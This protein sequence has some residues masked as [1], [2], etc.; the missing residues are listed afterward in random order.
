MGE[1]CVEFETRGAQRRAASPSPDTIDCD[2]T[3]SRPARYAYLN[4]GVVVGFAGSLARFYA[5]V[6]SVADEYH[7]AHHRWP[8]D[9]LIVARVFLQ[10][11]SS[12]AYDLDYAGVLCAHLHRFRWRALVHGAYGTVLRPLGTVAALLHFNGGSK[13]MLRKHRP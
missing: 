5:R 7:A 11:A 10:H 12:E 3:C 4:S 13:W 8:L 1:H 9:Q 2:F 6:I